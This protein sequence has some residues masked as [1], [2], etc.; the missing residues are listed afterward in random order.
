M[1]TDHYLN[2]ATL[3]FAVHQHLA[4]LVLN[5]WLA[6]ALP[7]EQVSLIKVTGTDK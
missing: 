1:E 6:S 4:C 3:N 2:K 7:N 5:E